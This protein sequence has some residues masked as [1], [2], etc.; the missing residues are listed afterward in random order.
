MSQ[1]VSERLAAF[2]SQ[3]SY[4]DIPD[5]VVEK[6]KTCLI[7]GIG[8]GLAGYKT[9]FPR[10]AAEIVTHNSS[11]SNQATLLYNGSRCSPMDAAFANA[12]LFHS[13]VQEDTHNT[14]HL[15]TVVIPV[16]L[17]LGEA[18]KKN[19]EEL[20]TALIAGYEIGGVLSK[21][22]TSKTT[23]RG[24][25]ASSI[26]GIF[27]A[28]AAASKL[29]NLNEEQTAH[30]LGF[31]ASFASGTL[32]AFTS[33]TMEWR[34]ENGLAAKNG[35]LSALLSKHGADASSH[36]FEGKGGFFHAFAGNRE[37]TQNITENLGKLY[38]ILNVTFKLYPVCAFNQTPVI[39]AI[40][41]AKDSQIPTEQIQSIKIE[42][43]AYEA[44]YPGMSS[45]GPFAN[46]SQTL[47]SAPYCVAV[48]LLD[49]K[50]TLS[51]LQQFNDKTIHKLI[52]KTTIISP[53]DFKPLCS[54]ITVELENGQ[55]IEREMNI[56]ED[57]YNFNIEEDIQIIKGLEKEMNITKIDLNQLITHIV[58]LEEIDNISVLIPT[59]SKV[60]E[61]I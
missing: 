59:F 22:Y 35:I 8:V 24:F 39:N 5:E 31:A 12:V 25:R 43:N 19:G 29:L 4:S 27:G 58:N 36:S 33:G 47:M 37:E 44:N 41:I 16:V 50:V 13:R 20:L 60:E 54:R 2:T 28:A 57:Y 10:I 42:M 21:H 17:A 6:A 46:I 14:A 18:G 3:L 9:D 48:S 34:F 1:T 51:N 15:G 55:M 32:E 7:H 38:E 52:S 26:Y 56:T 45:K 40:Q 49:S 30:A 61:K 53:I 11:K 23:P